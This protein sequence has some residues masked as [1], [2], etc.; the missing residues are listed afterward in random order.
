MKERQKIF[1]KC[2][3]PKVEIK[4]LN[5]LVD[6]KSFFDVPVK[7]KKEHTK[8]LLRLIKITI[9]QL[10]IYWTTNTFQSIIN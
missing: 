4:D 9:M 3:T 6:G 7:T 5:V 2:Y 1:L 8:K 10:V